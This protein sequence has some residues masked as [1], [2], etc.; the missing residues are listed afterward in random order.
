MTDQLKTLREVREALD[1]HVAQTRP[2]ER[3]AIARAN[4]DRLISEV[5]AVEP[6][7]WHVCSYNKDGTLSLEHAA[8][9]QEAAHEHINDAITEHGIEEAASWVVRPVYTHPRPTGFNAH[10]MATAAADGFRDGAASVANNDGY[11]CECDAAKDELCEGCHAY[12]NLPSQPES[13]T[14]G[15]NIAQRILHV[16]GRSNA[17]G[18]VEFGSVQAVEALV[19]Q[20]LR[21]LP[22]L[23]ELKRLRSD[24]VAYRKAFA[25]ALTADPKTLNPSEPA[26]PTSEAGLPP[27]PET[28]YELYYQWPDDED[29]FGGSETIDADGF[30]ADQMQSY[31]REAVAEAYRV[32]AEW[33]NRMP[34]NWELSWGSDDTESPSLWQV[35]KRVGSRN[36]REWEL[37]GEGATPKAAIDAAIRARGQGGAA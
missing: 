21:D 33:I 24:V 11:K 34:T 5:E 27:L 18:Y 23:A 20:A 14:A 36:D 10:G 15:M 26:Q 9:W 7:A 31:A 37:L 30:T 16:G 3:T 8:A 35:H 17:A 22:E 12:R 19:L 29:G 25:H 32:D 1:Y 4:L 2:I 13:P 6:V 28:M